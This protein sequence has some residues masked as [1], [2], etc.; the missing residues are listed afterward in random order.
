MAILLFQY[1]AI[2]NNE[3]LLIRVKYLQRSSFKIFPKWRNFVKSGHTALHKEID[4]HQRL[5]ISI[6]SKAER[7]YYQCTKIQL[8]LTDNLQILDAAQ[9][10][11]AR[12]QKL[13][14]SLMLATRSQKLATSLMLA[15]RSQMRGSRSQMMTT[16]S[17]KLAA[18][19]ML[20]TRSQILLYSMR[21]KFQTQK[22][23]MT[24]ARIIFDLNDDETCIFTAL[25]NDALYFPILSYGHLHCQI[26]NL[27]LFWAILKNVIFQ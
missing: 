19:Q 2:Q 27:I 9:I 14:I 11:T 20:A 7:R 12:Y 23:T 25:K 21:I 1:L 13:A 26:S 22:I 10:L 18:R 16:Q 3:N 8:Y 6:V 5:K 24:Q 4:S 15:T 17:Q